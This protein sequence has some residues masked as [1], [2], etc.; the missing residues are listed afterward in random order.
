MRRRGGAA[1]DPE[2]RERGDDARG[3]DRRQTSGNP[4]PVGSTPD[5]RERA[6]P[7]ALQSMVDLDPRVADVP[8]P[9]ARVF[10]ERAPKELAD[11]RRSFLGE[12]IPPRLGSE[13]RGDHVRRGL[14]AENAL[15]GQELVED[16][17]ER[18]DVGSL[19]H[20]LAARLLG[21]HE[22]R[23]AEDDA[24]LRAVAD[25]RRRQREVR[26]GTGRLRIESLRE[27][28]V[29]DLDPPVRGDLDVGR[30]QVP[31]DDAAI[32]RRLERL[33]DLTRDLER[34]VER[35]SAVR[36][37]VRERLSRH[38]LHHDEPRAFRFLQAV[39]RGDRGV[40]Q[41][42]EHPGLALEPRQALRVA[43]EL[44]GE[45]LDRD[46]PAQPVVVGA[47]DLSHSAGP[48]RAQNRID[49]ELRAR[50][51]GHLSAAILWEGSPKR[52]RESVAIG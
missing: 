30:L 33:G 24:G 5:D 18:P 14:P 44:L 42:G 29:E 26:L 37:P 51:E 46:L 16:A 17:A 9:A 52:G 15:A 10:L 11:P 19:V 43:G 2:D 4:A 28:E 47:I 20:R 3:D 41:G 8:E 25:E 50:R 23:G 45:G 7:E 39:D 27:A 38:E 34:L 22:L 49:P 6:G 1:G 36:Q 35:K 12:R 13:N 48:E 32:V 31:V 40:V 21:A